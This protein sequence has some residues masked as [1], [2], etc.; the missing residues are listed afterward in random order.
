[1]SSSG[2]PN[3]WPSGKE[4]TSKYQESYSHADADVGA[5]HD[6]SAVGHTGHDP[7]SLLHLTLSQPMSSASAPENNAPA[8]SL[9]LDDVTAMDMRAYD[10]GAASNDLSQFQSVDGYST[11]IPVAHQQWESVPVQSLPTHLGLGNSKSFSSMLGDEYQPQRAPTHLPHS[12]HSTG[13]SQQGRLSGQAHTIAPSG[14]AGPSHGFMTHAMTDSP[15]GFAPEQEQVQPDWPISGNNAWASMEADSRSSSAASWPT[16]TSRS[17][18]LES[19]SHES[20]LEDNRVQGS[21]RRQTEAAPQLLAYSG[22][23]TSAAPSL[24]RPTTSAQPWR[25]VNPQLPLM[26]PP[27]GVSEAH[28]DVAAQFRRFSSTSFEAEEGDDDMTGTQMGSAESAARRRERNNRRQGATCDQC[29]DKHL[30]CDLA[31]RASEPTGA[32]RPRSAGSTLTS[33]PCSKCLEK[34]LP[35]TK[36]NAPP[37]RR[38][39]RPSR[40]GKR[41]EQA[42]LM[43]GTVAADAAKRRFS[44][45]GVLSGRSPGGVQPDIGLNS[46]EQKLTGALL[47]SAATLRLLTCYFVTAHVQIPVV[48]FASFSSRYNLAAGDPRKMSIMLNGGSPLENI[49]SIPMTLPPGVPSVWP[50][51]GDS[52]ISTPGTTEAL[53]AALCAWGARFSDMPVVFGSQAKTLGLG[54]GI[55]SSS[56]PSQ[57]PGPTAAT[58][59]TVEG[60]DSDNSFDDQNPDSSGNPPTKRAKRKQGVACDTCRLRRVRCDLMERK[61]G[62]PCTRCQDKKI[63][64]TDEYIQRKRRDNETKLRKEREKLR[65]QL[66]SAGSGGEGPH[67]YFDSA[68]ATNSLQLGDNPDPLAWTDA[69]GVPAMVSNDQQPTRYGLARHAFCQEMLTRAVVLLHKHHLMYTPSVEAVQVMVL[70]THLFDLVDPSFTV[71]MSAATASHMRALSL[72]SVDEVD[73]TDT[74]AVENLFNLMQDKRVWCT[75]WTRDA[76]ACCVHRKAPQFLEE[77]PIKIRGSFSGA[78]ASG[79]APDLT[80][81]MGLSFSVMSLLQIGVLG[82]FV[83][84]HLDNIVSPDHPPPQERFPLLPSASDNIKLARA[85]H[86]AWK[87]NDALIDFFDRCTLKSWHQ[88]E[89]LKIHQPKVWVAAVKISSAMIILSTFRILGERQ[90]LNAAYL[91]AVSEAHGPHAIAADDIAQSQALRDLFEEA[92]HKTLTICRRVA[93]LMQKM[94]RRP[95]LT[96]QT[97]GILLKQLFAVAQFIARSPVATADEQQ[98]AAPESVLGAH[99]FA[100]PFPAVQPESLQQNNL[101][102]TGTFI[103]TVRPEAPASPSEL[104]GLAAAYD[105]P[106]PTFTAEAKEAEVEACLLALEQ[107]GYAWPVDAELQ[108]IRTLM[109]NERLSAF[110]F[111]AGA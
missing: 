22:A 95:S 23:A 48:D 46:P 71:Q 73:E 13:A 9:I 69:S 75:A 96:F 35:C 28:T 16:S 58:S 59:A 45:G 57:R 89:S 100:A 7:N 1:M 64:C 52:T 56:S 27:P 82:R 103:P 79:N 43:H 37:S 110:T 24:S 85:C 49:P 111:A 92:R 101:A 76:I 8:Q 97:G 39:P 50:G 11:F 36:T 17:T 10:V 4:T 2:W 66:G 29:R 109:Q 86:A 77:T 47:N 65:K 99:G 88:M 83:T 102:T 105:A 93:R 78:S 104:Y 91:Q 30:R 74:R 60:D 67:A 61:D 81:A 25:Q 55:A 90:R 34:G 32:G 44:A 42:R 19:F 21:Q 106:L 3:Q 87:S 70:L 53:I 63:V 12:Q 18:D 41:I 5:T 40:T 15:T 80:P 68:S 72:Q 31:D 98:R 20:H 62:M 94:H 51:T 107:I 33:V 14:I 26:P 54:T 108:S 84:R 38:Y 6:P